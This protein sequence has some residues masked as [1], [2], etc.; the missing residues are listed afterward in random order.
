MKPILVVDD[1]PQ[2]RA[3]LKTLLS[4]DGFDVLA[5]QD[6]A[7]AISVIREI[8][9]NIAGLV[10]DIE[11]KDMDGLELAKAVRGIISG[12]SDLVHYGAADFG[13]GSAAECAPVRPGS[14]AL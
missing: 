2:V 4:R 10:T 1:E 6:G 3:Y 12:A 5:V 7:I 11:M 14:K 13:N 9:G 8:G